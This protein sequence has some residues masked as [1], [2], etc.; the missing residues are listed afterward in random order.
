MPTRAHVATGVDAKVDDEWYN[1]Q[2]AN[3]PTEQLLASSA[4]QDANLKSQSGLLTRL[5]LV[6]EAGLPRMRVLSARKLR[7]LKRIPHSSEQEQEDALAA[8]ERC[9]KDPHTN[10]AN[11]LLVFFSHR[12]LRPN[13]CAACNCDRPWGSHERGECIKAGHRVGHP[14]D[15]AATKARALIEYA[16]WLEWWLGLE[17]ANRSD[18]VLGYE[19]DGEC[20]CGPCEYHRPGRPAKSK[21]GDIPFNEHTE[22]FFWI[23]FC[24]VDQSDPSA[25]MVALPA[26]VSVCSSILCYGTPG[27]EQRSW[28]QVELLM[29]ERR[30]LHTRV[31]GHNHTIACARAHARVRAHTEYMHIPTRTHARTHAR[32]CAHTH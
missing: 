4:F 11:A 13:W 5:H 19:A 17:K 12:W 26:S 2:G 28:C 3:G 8:V 27:Y 9:G 21:M 31:Y 29:A 22:L 23:D 18:V 20:K 30:S 24:C 16:D 10:G 14:D 7:T 1:S 32:A 6:T 15:A 25:D